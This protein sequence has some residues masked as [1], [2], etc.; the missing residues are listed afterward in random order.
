MA[1]PMKGMTIIVDDVQIVVFFHDVESESVLGFRES[2]DSGTAVTC[3]SLNSSS[4]INGMV[5]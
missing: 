1:L 4:L 2:A 5:I 3:N